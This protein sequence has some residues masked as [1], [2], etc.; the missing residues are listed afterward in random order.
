MNRLLQEQHGAVKDVVMSKEGTMSTKQLEPG[1]L[2]DDFRVEFD[3]ILINRLIT[4]YESEV[5]AAK[6]DGMSQHFCLSSN[7]RPCGQVLNI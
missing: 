4:D 5:I 2:A 1:T 7:N 3:N 6:L